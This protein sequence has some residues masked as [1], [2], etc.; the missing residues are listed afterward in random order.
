MVLLLQLSMFTPGSTSIFHIR[1]SYLDLI[2]LIE[3]ESDI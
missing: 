3:L 2:E 1:F